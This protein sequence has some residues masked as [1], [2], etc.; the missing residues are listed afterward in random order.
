MGDGGA[1]GGGGGERGLSGGCHRGGGVGRGR[2]RRGPRG[3][4][5]AVAVRG[6][7][8]GV[9]HG[10]AAVRA[11]QPGG[12]G[13]VGARLQGHQLAPLARLRLRQLQQPR[14]WYIAISSPHRPPYG[15]IPFL[16][17]GLHGLIA[18]FTF[19]LH[20][21][22]GDSILLNCGTMCQGPNL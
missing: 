19:R 3:R 12:A 13:D 7:P 10:L 20:G 22:I 6:R 5:G 4:R 1:N 18:I 8:G 15:P 21:L 17:R 2:R 11:L 14:G 9:G 16:L